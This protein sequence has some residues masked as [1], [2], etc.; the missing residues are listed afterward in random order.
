M[1]KFFD[2]FN[3]STKAKLSVYKAYITKYLKVLSKA[4]KMYGNKKDTVYMADLFAGPGIDEKGNLG[5]PLVLLDYLSQSYLDGMNVKILF[6]EK[7]SSNFAKLKQL[8]QERSAKQ[9]KWINVHVSNYDY[10]E[11]LPMIIKKHQDHTYYKRFFFIDPFG[12]KGIHLDDLKKILSDHDTEILLFLPISFI[13]RFKKKDDVYEAIKKFLDDF[14][15]IS[16]VESLSNDRAFIQNILETLRK[17]LNVFVDS[18]IIQDNNGKGHNCLIYFSSNRKG[19]EKF[20]EAKW[21]IDKDEGVGY[22]KNAAQTCS[23]LEDFYQDSL[24][25]SLLDYFRTGNKSNREVRNYCF[26]HGFLCRHGNNSLEK[27]LKKGKITISANMENRK[28]KNKCFYLS[29]DKEDIVRIGL[30]NENN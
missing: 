20:V 5:S 16:N 9:P 7:D 13:Y 30:A 28:I 1:E 27:L 26:E 14:I 24:E 25:E 18:F 2:G 17:K 10:N 23:F 12:Y 19:L 21:D 22:E 6:N 11:L 8:I 15:S 3:E 4:Y 29:N